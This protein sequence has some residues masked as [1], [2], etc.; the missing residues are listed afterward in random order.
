[1]KISVLFAATLI[2]ITL[3]FTGCGSS[4]FGKPLTVNQATPIADILQAPDK[5]NGKRV[6][7]EGKITEVCEMMGCWIMI[8]GNNEKETLRFKVDDGVITFP[9]SVKGKVARA[10]GI[11]SV[12]ELSVDD[13]ITEG[14]HHADETGATFDPSTV[15]APKTRIQLNGEGAVV[16]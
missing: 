14:Q 16:K 13:Q 15:T 1:M 2:A 6:L 11:V 12:K 10:E 7:V 8:Q 5:Y 3:L 9:M 4:E